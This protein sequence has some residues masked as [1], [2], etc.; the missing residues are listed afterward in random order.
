M[1]TNTAAKQWKRNARFPEDIRPVLEKHW[2]QG[3]AERANVATPWLWES[4]RDWVS[5]KVCQWFQRR[6]NGSTD[7]LPGWVLRPHKTVNE[8]DRCQALAAACFRHQ[9]TGRVLSLHQLIELQAKKEMPDIFG[10]FIHDFF[11]PGWTLTGKQQ[12]VVYEFLTSRYARMSDGKAHT[13]VVYVEDMKEM[14]K[15]Y[16]AAI[17]GFLTQN[18]G[19]G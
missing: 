10:I 13:T 8:I 16:G 18:Y 12:Q 6:L 9:V 7:D 11:K 4:A 17:T 14:S 2:E 3:M 5:P 1:A 15:S 19:M